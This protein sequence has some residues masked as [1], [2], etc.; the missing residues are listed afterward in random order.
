MN[1]P[2]ALFQQDLE[3]AKNA[4]GDRGNSVCPVKKSHWKTLRGIITLGKGEQLFRG[5]LSSFLNLFSEKVSKPPYPHPPI[6]FEVTI[7]I[8]SAT[9]QNV[10]G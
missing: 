5:S 10:S 9:F 1:F 2:L 8:S 7:Y 3:K 4:N 6:H